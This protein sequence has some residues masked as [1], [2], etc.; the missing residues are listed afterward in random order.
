MLYKT[1]KLFQAHDHNGID[2]L[3]GRYHTSGDRDTTHNEKSLLQSAVNDVFGMSHGR[4]LLTKESYNNKYNVNRVEGY[5]NPYC[6]VWTKSSMYEEINHFIWNVA[7]MRRMQKL[8]FKT[9]DYMVL[10]KAKT[11]EDIVDRSIAKWEQ[12]E[13]KEPK[14]LDLG[15]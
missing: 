7:E 2:T 14:Q 9:R 15:L 8:Y 13:K 12:S 4:N 6:R 5:S 1:H 11:L 10:R 3:I